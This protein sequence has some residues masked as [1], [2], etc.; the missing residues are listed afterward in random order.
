MFSFKYSARPN[1]LASKRMPDDVSD[2]EKTARIVALQSLQR[3]IQTR[4]LERA[5]GSVVH[6]LV[7]SASRRREAEISGR[8]SGNVVVNCP[9]P[10]DPGPA[11]EWIG[12][13]VPA[14]ITAAGP[15][16]LRGDVL[17][18]TGGIESAWRAWRC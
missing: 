15:H 4:L 18:E 9:L 10:A 12:R 5:I 6:V 11:S 17:N 13:T 2:E 14:R 7:D 8:T 1:T 16:S 3:E